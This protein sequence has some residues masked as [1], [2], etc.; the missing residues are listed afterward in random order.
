MRFLAN[1]NFPLTSVRSLRA[2]GYDV[3]AISEE[4]PGA[5]DAAVLAQA[6]REARIVLTIRPGL[7]GVALSI[8]IA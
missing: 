2:A 3:A 4:A 5:I 6:A 1:E 7:W 8:Q